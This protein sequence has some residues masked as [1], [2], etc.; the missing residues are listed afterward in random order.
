MRKSF[1][2]VFGV[3]LKQKKCIW[4]ICNTLD[5]QFTGETRK[6]ASDFISKHIDDLRHARRREYVYMHWYWAHKK[7]RKR[8]SRY[9]SYGEV[10]EDWFD[11]SMFT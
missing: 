3:T 6:D 8:C 9:A 10:V 2:E 5:V 4:D 1:D 7:P 11:F